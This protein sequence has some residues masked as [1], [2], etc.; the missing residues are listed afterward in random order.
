MSM[1]TPIGSITQ[2][3]A[4]KDFIELENIDTQQ[5]LLGINNIATGDGSKIKLEKILED[6]I[7]TDTGNTLEIGSDNKLLNIEEDTGV[8]AG[9]YTY[10]QNLVVNSKGRI[11]SV[12]SGSPASVPIATTLQAGIVKPDGN[13]ITVE[14]DGTI[15]ANILGYE[16]GDIVIRNTPTNDAGKHLLDGALIQYG[17]YSAFIDYIASLVTDYPNLFTTEANWQAEVLATGFCD[18]YVYDSTNNTVRLPKIGNQL[19]HNLPSTLGVK[20]NGMSLGITDG[21]NSG[22]ICEYNTQLRP[23]SGMLGNPVGTARSGQDNWSGTSIGVTSDGTK[24]GLIAETDN[25]NTADVYY[26]VVIATSTKTAIQVDIDEIATDLNGKADVDFTNVN[27]QGTALS[28]HWM[29][30]DSSSEIQITPPASS[31]SGSTLANTTLFTAPCNGWVTVEATTNNSSGRFWVFGASST[32][33]SSTFF[34][35]IMQTKVST[36]FVKKGEQVLLRGA[37]VSVINAILFY[38]CEGAKWEVQ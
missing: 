15:N 6:S 36:I 32:I 29:T 10:P 3:T 25:I 31:S 30:T 14:D 11:T 17:S 1:N 21:T 19:V 7:S 8:Q 37:Y 4:I 13:T 2:T 22:A 38:P 33:I 35:S 23:N 18:K 27:N 34:G 20:G 16:V 9:N 24:S 26:Y 12:T 5:Y 28:T